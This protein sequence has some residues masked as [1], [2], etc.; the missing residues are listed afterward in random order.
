MVTVQA[1]VATL[2]HPF[3]PVNLEPATDELATR[4]TDLPLL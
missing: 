4:T 2:S 3:H 1:L